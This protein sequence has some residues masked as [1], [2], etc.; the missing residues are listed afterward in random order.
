MR[1]NSFASLILGLLFLFC[2]QS[3][4]QTNIIQIIA[5]DMSWSDLST[6]LTNLGN[7][8][9]YYQTPN[10]DALATGGMSF[11]S[12]YAQPSCNPTRAALLTGQYAPK[13]GT[14]T[15]GS[16]NQ[17]PDSLLIGP[18][19]GNNIKLESIT[20][21]E[22]LQAAGYITAHIGKFHST[23]QTNDIENSHGFDFNIGGNSSGGVDNVNP[24]FARLNNGNTQWIFG[25]SHGPELDPYADPYTQQYI[26]ENLMPFANGNDPSILV[27]TPKH[28]SDAM[29]DATID[30]LE[31]RTNDGQPFFVNVAFNAVHTTVNSRPDLEEKYVGLPTSNNPDHD[32]PAYAGL[33]EGMDQAIGRIVSFVNDNGLTGDTLIVFMS[34]NGGTNITDNFPL[35]GQKGAFLEGGI[36]VPLICLL[37][38][39]PSPRDQRGSRMPSSA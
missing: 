9:P 3:I 32:D 7:G 19:D 16:L 1:L 27:N 21:G 25:N 20:L 18:D 15:V 29:A 28:L 5:D 23:N 36:R 8:S 39:S 11:T 2:Q 31:D 12:F 38:T 6:G 24:Y 34:D 13:N 22:T 4:A 33:L 17:N 35:S 14:H 37:Y 26:N 10:I 30:F